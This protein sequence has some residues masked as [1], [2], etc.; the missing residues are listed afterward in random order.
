VASK[1]EGFYSGHY[2]ISGVAAKLSNHIMHLE[3]F[4]AQLGSKALYA[5]TGFFEG[6]DDEDIAAAEEICCLLRGLPLAIVQISD[7][8]RDSASSYIEFLALYPKSLAKILAK[9]EVT[10]E[11][12]HTLST[13]WELSS[14]NLPQDAS[15]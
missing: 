4:A 1:H 14:H 7:F 9:G 2:Q 11:Y 10:L 8:I 6:T 5:L 15:T 12:N 3:P 13:A